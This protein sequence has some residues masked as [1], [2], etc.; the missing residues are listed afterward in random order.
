[1]GGSRPD[2]N[3]SQEE[4]RRHNEDEANR[5]RRDNADAYFA[6]RGWPDGFKWKSY[7]TK[8][9][10][11]AAG[12][13]GATPLGLL[14]EGW[15]YTKHSWLGRKLGYQEP[16]IHLKMNTDG[17]YTAT[18]TEV[19]DFD[20]DIGRSMDLLASGRGATSIKID[21]DKPQYVTEKYLKKAMRQAEKRGL[22]IEFG[23]GVMAYLNDPKRCSDHKRK[24]LLAMRDIVNQNKQMN[25][26]WLGMGTNKQLGASANALNK[27]NEKLSSITAKPGKSQGESMVERDLEGKTGEARLKEIE[28]QLGKLDERIK[29]ANDAHDKLNENLGKFIGANNKPDSLLRYRAK[30]L[31]GKWKRFKSLLGFTGVGDAAANRIGDKVGKLYDDG[32]KN[33]DALLLSLKDEIKDLGERRE[34]WKAELD[35]MRGPLKAEA[36]DAAK[37]RLQ[38]NLTGDMK[39]VADLSKEAKGTT[40]LDVAKQKQLGE[41]NDRLNLSGQLTG[42]EKTDFDTLNPRAKNSGLFA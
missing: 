12:V 15:Y 31:Q 33:R 30:G 40:P 20:R 22:S 7:G 8:P 25:D 26:L 42:T 38:E 4:Q 13:S 29:Q 3:P 1:M 41:A 39:T 11:E 32:K 36:M 23:P 5:K 21:W 28:N 2:T 27:G 16:D 19:K 9:K 34:A 10:E 35:K 17:T 18:P 24:R 6:S 37:K 14:D